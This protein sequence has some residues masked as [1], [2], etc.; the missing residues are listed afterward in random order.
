MDTVRWQNECI[1]LQR[2][3][4]VF[5]R[6]VLQLSTALSST[7]DDLEATKSALSEAEAESRR[8]ALQLQLAL[9]SKTELTLFM[10]EERE[11]AVDDL[12]ALTQY[13]ATARQEAENDLRSMAE[14]LRICRSERDSFREQLEN[15]KNGTL[16]S[17]WPT[18]QLLHRMLQ[19]TVVRSEEQEHRFAE[20][21]EIA[22]MRI[23]AGVLVLNSEL[24]ELSVLLLRERSTVQ[25][26]TEAL[27][28]YRAALRDM[29]SA[30]AARIAQL[31]V[32]ALTPS[33][34]PPPRHARGAGWGAKA[35]GHG[36][37]VRLY[38]RE[39]IA[40]WGQGPGGKHGGAHPRPS[41]EACQ[42][43]L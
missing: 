20:S 33:A 6:N 28:K 15:A 14:E 39:K 5:E 37:C 9:Q 29:Q 18:V 19:K 36:A 40:P 2:E 17:S 35:R 34:R 8:L 21:H 3:N 16:P 4:G 22:M 38:A 1:R 13:E 11:R 26:L 32:A 10:T 30:A 42:G 25:G 27:E 43:P 24:G 23:R 31:E 41:R 7:H 12:K